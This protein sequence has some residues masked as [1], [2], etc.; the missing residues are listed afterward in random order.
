MWEGSLP[1]TVASCF[2]LFSSLVAYNKC[3]WFVGKQFLVPTGLEWTRSFVCLRYWE[4]PPEC[5]FTN[6][7][8]NPPTH[9]KLPWEQLS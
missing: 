5:V 1:S 4:T 9:K 6:W 2:R 3:F 7:P 8:V